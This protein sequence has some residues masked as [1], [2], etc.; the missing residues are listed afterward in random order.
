MKYSREIEIA[1][2]LQQHELSEMQEFHN[3][4]VHKNLKMTTEEFEELALK[5]Q[6]SPLLQTLLEN[7]T[8]LNDIIEY[9]G[10]PKL[11]FRLSQNVSF[12][13]IFKRD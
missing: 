3:E 12:E 6:R 10:Y 4:Q 11:D 13:N 1:L 8:N 2:A 9:S 5:I 7:P